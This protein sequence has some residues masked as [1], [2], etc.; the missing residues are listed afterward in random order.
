MGPELRTVKSP[1][2]VGA[3]GGVQA[4]LLREGKEFCVPSI[5]PEQ[6]TVFRPRRRIDK[7]GICGILY[8]DRLYPDPKRQTPG[9]RRAQSHASFAVYEER[10]TAEDKGC[11]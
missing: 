8:A 6:A 10:Q 4:P 2:G 11:R 7:Y 3:F 9:N 1:G 5:G